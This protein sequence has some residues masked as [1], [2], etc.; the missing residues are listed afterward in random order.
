M[1]ND[2]LPPARLQLKQPKI[3]QETG[4]PAKAPQIATCQEISDEQGNNLL[5]FEFLGNKH[6]YKSSYITA[7]RKELKNDHYTFNPKI[8]SSSKK[9]ALKRRN[10]PDFESKLSPTRGNLV[11]NTSSYFIDHSAKFGT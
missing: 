6:E 1:Y 3:D 9:L 7:Y 10:N 4:S 2:I 11:G 5:E 8:N